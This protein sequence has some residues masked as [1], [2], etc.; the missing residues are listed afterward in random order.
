MLFSKFMGVPNF[1]NTE[2]KA[3]YAAAKA[4]NPNR[5]SGDTRD[6]SFIEAVALNPE[7][8]DN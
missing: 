5:W 6:W 1:Y 3:V 7:K 8:I 2:R 4:Q